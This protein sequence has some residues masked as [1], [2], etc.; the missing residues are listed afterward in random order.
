MQVNVKH[1]SITK[2]FLTNALQDYI[3]E[4]VLYL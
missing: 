4:S 2:T 3:F 1:D